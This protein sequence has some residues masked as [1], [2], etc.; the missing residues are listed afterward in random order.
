MPCA[1]VV[2]LLDPSGKRHLSQSY[3]VIVNCAEYPYV[4]DIEQKLSDPFYLTKGEQYRFNEMKVSV[5]SYIMSIP[6]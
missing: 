1:V 2:Q 5:M 6:G 4:I 3:D